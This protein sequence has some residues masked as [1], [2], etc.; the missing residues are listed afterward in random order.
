VAIPADASGQ[1]TIQVVGTEPVP[2][3]LTVQDGGGS[4][5]NL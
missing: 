4:I 5:C 1:L 2:G 3:T